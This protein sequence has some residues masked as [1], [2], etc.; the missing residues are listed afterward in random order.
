MVDVLLIHPP[1]RLDAETCLNTALPVE[2]V[3][4]GLLSIAAFLKMNGYSVRVVDVPRL[5][6]QNFSKEEILSFLN[7]YKPEMIG[8]EL[9][10]LHFSRGAIELA[11]ELKNANPNAFIVV[12]GTHASL[13][14]RE[15]LSSYGAWIDEVIVGEGEL[16]MLNLLEKTPPGSHVLEMDQ[17]PPYDPDVIAPKRE[18]KTMFLNTCRGSCSNACM[19]CLG[20]CMHQLTGRTALFRHSAAWIVEQIQIFIEK[21]YTDIGLQDPW[22]SGAGV[23]TFIES[24]AEA[25]KKEGISDLLTRFN[26]ECLPGALNGEQL[27]TLADIG[28]TDIDYGCESGSKKVL[29]LVKRPITPQRACDAVEKTA[30][31]GIIPIT[32]WM[33]GFPRE[34]KEDVTLTIQLIRQ[35]AKV[36][37]I[38]HWVTPIVVLPGT[39][40]Y[41]KR[42]ELGIVQQLHTFEDFAVYSDTQKKQWAWYPELLSHHTKEQSA[43][44]ILMNAINLKLASLECRETIL[45]AIKPL[46]KKL[47]D[48]HPDWAEDD[49]LFKSVD[50]ALKSM[51]GTYF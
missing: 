29:E 24:L 9:N 42:E 13:F 46:E 37:G 38:P 3:G 40:L 1:N 5:F 33:T 10:W 45:T 44:E 22:T 25:F 39:P 35:I 16:P 11:K 27:E 20:S 47:Y 50:Y 49:R 32:Y 31:H 23:G 51:K 48:R 26:L 15:I 19:Y 17:I 21:G 41:E 18:G 4:Y 2:V 14:K 43:E 30:A 12:G 6:Q 28:V 36:G 7:S 8:I 34:T